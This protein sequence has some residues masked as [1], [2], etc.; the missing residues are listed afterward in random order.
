MLQTRIYPVTGFH[1]DVQESY[2]DVLD[3]LV[4]TPPEYWVHFTLENGNR[5]S[6]QRSLMFSFGCTGG[7]HRSVYCAQ[8]LAE[9]IHDKFGIEVQIVHREQ[10][11]QQTLEPKS[12][13][14]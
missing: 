2:D 7:Q 8:H 11:I 5:V 13:K 1:V 3:L 12:V 10:G 14:S 4:R 6:F 9:H